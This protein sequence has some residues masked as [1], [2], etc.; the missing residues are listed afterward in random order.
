MI[1]PNDCPDCGARM[2]FAFPKGGTSQERA[3]R[4]YRRCPKRDCGRSVT[5]ADVQRA[6][7]FGGRPTEARRRRRANP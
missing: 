7:R 6:E 1:W 2:T 3:E 5:A 4:A